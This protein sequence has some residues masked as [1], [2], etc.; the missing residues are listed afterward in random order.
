LIPGPATK[1]LRLKD[2]KMTKEI[3]FEILK[4]SA[5]HKFGKERAELLTPAI[6]EI[7]GSLASISDYPLE[8]EEEPAFF[9]RSALR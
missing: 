3:F 7:S 1:G 5:V 2:T 9:S 6:Q 4:E 8:L